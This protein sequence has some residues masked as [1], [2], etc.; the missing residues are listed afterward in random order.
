M[1]SW[2]GTFYQSNGYYRS[3]AK[4]AAEAARDTS[5][6]IE[7]IIKQVKDGAILANASTDAFIAVTSSTKMVSGLVSEIAAASNEQAQGIEQVNRAVVEIDKVT[8]S[9]AGA[10]EESASASEALKGEAKQMG[11][12]VGELFR[13]I[14]GSGK[15]KQPSNPKGGAG[16]PLQL[17]HYEE[18]S[19]NDF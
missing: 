15:P 11:R 1:H 8:Q 14:E 13:L 12:I 19:F 9:T 2:H 7:G 6:L 4:R 10:A 5:G 17:V 18:K 3:L 16:N